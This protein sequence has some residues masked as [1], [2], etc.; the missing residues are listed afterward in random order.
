M[1]VPKTDVNLTALYSELNKFGNN[2]DYNRAMKVAKQRACI[3]KAEIVCFSKA[4]Q[5]FFMMRPASR[6]LAEWPN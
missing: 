1:A 3:K 2:G 6:T 4:S 5:H